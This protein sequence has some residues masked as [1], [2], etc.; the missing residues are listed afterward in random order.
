M[1][2]LCIFKRKLQTRNWISNH[3]R[4]CSQTWNS[5]FFLMRYQVKAYGDA[6]WFEDMM[7]H[8]GLNFR[9][10]HC[11]GMLLNHS[12]ARGIRTLIPSKLWIK[13]CSTHIQILLSGIYHTMEIRQQL[14]RKWS[15][16]LCNIAKIC[17]CCLFSGLGNSS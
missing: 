11:S 1:S 12:P 17:C 15:C 16:F 7:S 8:N 5:F 4:K 2:Q 6:L 3:N 13:N 10:M 14:K 9:N